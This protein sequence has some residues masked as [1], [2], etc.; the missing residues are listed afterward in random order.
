MLVGRRLLRTQVKPYQFQKALRLGRSF[1]LWPFSK[2]SKTEAPAKEEEDDPKNMENLYF[3]I[4]G[5]KKENAEQG[6]Y[7]V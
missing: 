7:A 2:K 5:I 1:G 3:L 6:T 4:E